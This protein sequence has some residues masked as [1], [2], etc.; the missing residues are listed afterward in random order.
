LPLAEK[1]LI[2]RIRRQATTRR[3]IVT[4]IGDD[5][6]VLRIP[7]AH[8]VLVTTDF[9]LEGI[10]F[11]RDWHPPGSIGHRC[12]TRG[13]SDIAAMGGKPIAAF[14]SLALPRTL[15]QEWVDRFARGLLALAGRFKISLAG[16]DTAE[17]PDGV[18]ADIIVVGSVPK[19]KAILRSGA[20]SGDIICVSG[21][22]GGS[23]A[24]LHRMM[25]HPKRKLNPRE[26]LR[27]FFPEPRVA[28][29][30]FLREKGLA[31]AMIDIS[32]GL[33]T[34]LAHVCE[35]SGVRAEIHAEALP[36][37]AIGRPPR[38]V[39]QRFALHGGEDYELLFTVPRGRPIPARAAGVPITPIGRITQG[40]GIRL[41]SDGSARPLAPRGW[42]HFKR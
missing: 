35:E 34:D 33:S 3:G 7:P 23:A 18:L 42:E 39:E 36:F 8:E 27:H 29:G 37:A 20:R 1:A 41:H 14:V 15:P 40:E 16:G 32:D 28:L 12:L 26:Y 22:L 9:S 2:A 13:L 30:R 11:R 19:G 21:G 38:K 31:S 10:H 4:G 25:E 17:S 5:A 6:A 24:T